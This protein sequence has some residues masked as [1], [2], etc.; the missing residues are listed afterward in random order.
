MWD[1][2]GAEASPPP[3][4]REA[5]GERLTLVVTV[6]QD[7]SEIAVEGELDLASIHLLRHALYDA[8][9]GPG[10]VRVD[11][12]RVTFMDLAALRALV[13]AHARLRS[14]GRRMVVVVPRGRRPRVMSVIQLAAGLTIEE[15]PWPDAS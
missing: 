10:L 14:L 3:E 1:S 6:D 11:L 9:W 12:R 2:P 8:A 4:D 15:R 13:E 7:R 5:E